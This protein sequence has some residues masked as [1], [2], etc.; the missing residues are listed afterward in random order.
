MRY[1]GRRPTSQQLGGVLNQAVLSQIPMEE[2]LTSHHQIPGILT[3]I[4][5]REIATDR[6]LLHG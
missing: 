5:G 1:S 6:V 3:T 2:R 4:A